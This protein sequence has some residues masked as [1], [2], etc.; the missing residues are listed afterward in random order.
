[1][2]PD[3]H[4]RRQLAKLPQ[5]LDSL[6]AV[7]REAYFLCRVRRF[8]IEQAARSL[9]LEAAVVRTYLV[10]AQRACHAALS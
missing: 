7:C 10:Q 2:R 8:S 6:P 9:G 3:A 4:R 5:T 1:M